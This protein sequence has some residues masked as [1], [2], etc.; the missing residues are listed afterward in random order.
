MNTSHQTA[1]AEQSHVVHTD[2]TCKGNPGVGAWAY[3]IDNPDGTRTEAAGFLPETTNNRSELL[4]VGHAL[5]IIPPGSR[6]LLRTDSAYVVNNASKW[7]AVWRSN[8]WKTSGK[9]PVK[10]RDLWE[11]LDALMETREVTFQ[12]VPGHSGVPGNERADE[13]ANEATKDCAS[14]GPFTFTIEQ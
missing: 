14:I 11:R 9:K 3:L 6:V 7:L 1:L 2:G 8:G 4:A 10:N 12:H 13:L 5:E